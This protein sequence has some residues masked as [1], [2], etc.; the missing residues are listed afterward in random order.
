MYTVLLNGGIHEEGMA[1]L[2]AEAEVL[3]PLGNDQSLGL[4]DKSAVHAIIAGSTLDLSGRTMDL[5]PSLRVLG[6]PGI[7]VDNIEIPAATE[8]GICVVNTPDA[9]SESTAEHAV[10]LIMN[11]AARVFDGDRALRQGDWSMRKQARGVELRGKTLG[12]VGLGRIGMRVAEICRLGLGMR[13]LA[14]D[15]YVDPAKG[16]ALGLETV[17][18][19][20]EVVAQADFLT[21]HIPN[22]TQTRG[23]VDAAALAAMK[24]TA[25]LVNC[26][27]GPVVDEKALIRALRE[28]TIAGAGVDVYDPEP[29]AMD[30]PLFSLPNT[31]CTPHI[32]SFTE[33]GVRAMGVG[34]AEGVLAVLRGERPT[35]LGQLVNPQVWDR[36]R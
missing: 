31:V 11:L 2:E 17:D 3:G 27:R 25:Y 13:V 29:P 35:G 4:Q 7:G 5:F 21:L 26:A 12:V 16:E 19:L 20:M 33:D 28:G 36:R 9:P 22:T 1:M 10:A 8:R 30:N 15:P 34:A 24:P 23:L 14:Y 18:E 6:R 32:A